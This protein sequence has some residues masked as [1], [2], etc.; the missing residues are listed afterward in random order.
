MLEEKMQRLKDIYMKIQNTYHPKNNPDERYFFV[1]QYNQLLEEMIIEG[2]NKPLDDDITL[3]FG[4]ITLE[5]Y[6]FLEKLQKNEPPLVYQIIKEASYICK[7]RVQKTSINKSSNSISNIEVLKNYKGTTPKFF[8]INVAPPV[9]YLPKWFEEKKEAMIFL[10]K[11]FS[12]L[13]AIGYFPVIEYDK[14]IYVVTHITNFW[15]KEY[16]IQYPNENNKFI[17]LKDFE[18]LVIE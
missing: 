7:V 9:A 11:L 4:Y 5:Y 16:E 15:P 13:G 17:K 2:L 18:F 10:N 6:N 12:P 1:V 3:D 14:N 8:R